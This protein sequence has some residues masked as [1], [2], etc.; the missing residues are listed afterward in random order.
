MSSHQ[1]AHFRAPLQNC[2]F[3]PEIREQWRAQY[4]WQALQTHHRYSNDRPALLQCMGNHLTHF[5]AQQQHA[6][7]RILDIGC[8]TGEVSGRLLSPLLAQIAVQ[9]LGVDK[10]A[11]ALQQAQQNLLMPGLQP[12]FLCADYTRK[13]W[14]ETLRGQQFDLICLIHSAYYLIDRHESFLQ[15]LHALLHPQGQ[16]LLLHNPEG[17][18][19]LKDLAANLG[20]FVEAQLFDRE[21]RPPQV[22]DA[23]FTQLAE[24]PAQISP[25]AEQAFELRLL[26]EFYL[27]EYPL[28]ALPTEARRQY[29]QRWQQHLQHTPYFRN[30]HELLVL[31]RRQ[32]FS[33]TTN[34]GYK[35]DKPTRL[36]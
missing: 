10:S 13:A 6:E 17:H 23:V 7:L 18:A 21:I 30:Q 26:L 32:A 22:S 4:Y 14:D 19:Q 31:K 33:K 34:S 20:Y 16:V 5:I 11:D 2:V 9:Y 15:Q 29:I 12:R 1:H 36:F 35:R 28:A 25:A 3:D 27:S 8:G 24:A